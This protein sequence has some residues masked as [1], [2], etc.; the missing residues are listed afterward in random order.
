M[1]HEHFKNYLYGMVV[2]I[3]TYQVPTYLVSKGGSYSHYYVVTH[4]FFTL[5][6]F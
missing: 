2:W 5:I 1:A 6:E 4:F 3:H